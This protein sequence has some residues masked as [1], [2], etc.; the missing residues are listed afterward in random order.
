MTKEEAA[1]EYA[2]D[3]SDSIASKAA[4]DAIRDA[5]KAGA[6]WM[7]SQ[8]AIIKGFV[9]RDKDGQLCI[10]YGDKPH[11]GGCDRWWH[12]EH[13]PTGDWMNLPEKM[14]PELKWEDEPIEVEL[15]IRKK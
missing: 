4:V 6:E 8:G 2:P 7:V 11:R 15:T 1:E 12:P 3:F 9:A 13:C 14:F 5:F 10:F